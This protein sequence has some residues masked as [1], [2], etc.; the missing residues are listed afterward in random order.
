MRIKVRCSGGHELQVGDDLAGARIR[1]PQCKEIISVPEFALDAPIAPPRPRTVSKNSASVVAITVV[2]I[3]G[4]AMIAV[5]LLGVFLWYVFQEPERVM[6]GAHITEQMRNTPGA[7]VV[8]ERTETIEPAKIIL[9][10][11]PPPIT[12]PSPTQYPSKTQDTVQ[13]DSPIRVSGTDSAILFKLPSIAWS[14]AYDP[15]LGRIALTD[16]K[17]GIVIHSID[18][19]MKGKTDP[20]SILG[21]AGKPSAVCFKQWNGSRWFIYTSSEESEINFVDTGSLEIASKTPLIHNSKVGFLASSNDPAD[22]Y[23]YFIKNRESDQSQ[24]A[25]FGRLN[26]QTKAFDEI[27][28]CP[29]IDCQISPDGATIYA[30]S[31]ERDVAQYAYAFGNWEDFKRK[32]FADRATVKMKTIVGSSVRLPGNA[33]AIESTFLEPSFGDS[34]HL[35]LREVRQSEFEPLARS[36]TMPIAIGTSETGVVVGSLITGN[37]L[38]KFDVPADLQR[39]NRAAIKAVLRSDPRYRMRFATSIGC[40][41]IDGYI[42]D[43][44]EVAIVSIDDHL[45]LVPF[46]G[47]D[48]PR[49][50]PL[51]FPLRLPNAAAVGQTLQIPVPE[52]AINDRVS[53]EFRFLNEV[54]NE[55]RSSSIELPR[56]VDGAIRWTPDRRIV[57]ARNIHVTA[58][59][60]DD[61]REWIWPVEIAYRPTEEKFDFYVQGIAGRPDSE[62]AVVW[63]IQ[64]SDV[65][66]RYPK[67]NSQPPKLIDQSTLAIYDTVKREIRVQ[68]LLPYEIVDAV[69]H[70]TG[71]YA[72]SLNAF[73]R[74]KNDAYSLGR[75]LRFDIDSLRLLGAVPVDAFSLADADVPSYRLEPRGDELFA[76]ARRIRVGQFVETSKG[77]DYRLRIPDLSVIEITSRT[78]NK[79]DQVDKSRPIERGILWDDTLTTPRLIL[80]PSPFLPNPKVFLSN[81]VEFSS[82]RNLPGTY[83]ENLHAQIRST[84]RG[85]MVFPPDQNPSEKGLQLLALI[86]FPESGKSEGQDFFRLTDYDELLR[87]KECESVCGSNILA[88]FEG[89]VFCIV[90]ES[91]PK[92]PSPFML[93]EKQDH[94]AVKAGEKLR[95]TYSAPGAK[96][97]RLKVVLNASVNPFTGNLMDKNG[98]LIQAP[99]MESSDGRFEFAFEPEIVTKA[100][101]DHLK[102]I[103]ITD[104]QFS[105]RTVIDY[106]RKMETPY[107]KLVNRTLATLPAV[108]TVEVIADHEDGQQTAKLTHFVLVEVPIEDLLPRIESAIA[109]NNR[110]T[111]S[112][113]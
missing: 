100:I 83:L 92:A 76:F 28:G 79:L 72:A 9:P 49:S 45:M 26:L 106:I 17:K 60:G 85:L 67:D 30:K 21:V 94:F 75:I 56:I 70:P 34:S 68:V 6:G 7:V 54:A 86:G 43:Q 16:D 23:L 31:K 39:Q 29:F 93:E 58:I 61:K 105:S 19:L 46:K 81:S 69:L 107:R 95:W 113:R 2:S 36:G 10:N 57:G 65:E 110:E 25:K 24:D 11:S 103:Y 14:T 41:S 18:D 74:T 13:E 4:V 53:F 38:A 59:A 51:D 20:I 97:Y 71:V 27:D 77:S 15:L 5:S 98:R 12:P 47:L 104:F 66:I 82:R 89:R 87:S 91:L 42:D 22:P 102:T 52:S 3:L 55:D 111:G 32:H 1:C 8:I 88:T 62:L 35:V 99:D 90:G 33:V 50:H 37:T 80:S 40:V 63:G 108:A 101:V 96:K 78:E 109:D 112:G 44:R 84:R 73:T 64:H 48:L